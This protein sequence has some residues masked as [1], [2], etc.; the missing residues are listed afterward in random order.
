ML[1][2]VGMPS[3][4]MRW[5][6]T[7]SRRASVSP[8]EP[9][10]RAVLGG[11]EVDRGAAR[12]ERDAD[13]ADP[14]PGRHAGHVGDGQQLGRRAVEAGPRW[15]DPDGDRQRG[16]VDA[17][18]QGLHLVAPDDGTARVDLQHEGLGAVGVRAGDGLVDGVDRD[19]VEQAAD[20]QHVDG[21]ER[22]L[23]A[24]GRPGGRR[25]G[26]RAAPVRPPWRAG[27]SLVCAKVPPE[28][29]DPVPLLSASRVTIVAGKGGVGK[30]TVTAVLARA[31]AD[32]GHRVLA[33]EL[34]GKPVLRSL[35]GE[36]PV[37]GHLASGGAGRVPPRPRVRTHRQAAVG[38]R[39]DRRRGDRGARH[40]R[41]RRARQDQAARAQ[42][43]SGT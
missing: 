26:R 5:R 43:A 15:P 4:E 10:R 14:R 27:R 3:S 34:D 20:L 40:R 35:V 7:S 28:S 29:V 24:V 33:I 41:H 42:R 37:R 9:L 16:V 18:E 31:A 6:N 21:P 38:V 36:P 8:S 17:L 23:G 2:M 30:T 1:A 22:R 13:V 11:A 12:A 32:A 39:R 19:G 25:P